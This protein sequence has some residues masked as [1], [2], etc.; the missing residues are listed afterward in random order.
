MNHLP[1]P[2]SVLT[3]P[4]PG[5]TELLMAGLTLRVISLEE[6]TGMQTLL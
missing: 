3:A 6:L 5:L 2:D 1:E 4:I